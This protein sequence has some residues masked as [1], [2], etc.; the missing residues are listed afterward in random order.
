MSSANQA[1]VGRPA[2]A[3]R[4][5]INALRAL[6]VVLVVLYHFRVPPFSIGGFVGVDVFFVI[7]GYLMTRIVVSG[8]E[9][10]DFS[11]LKFYA[12]RARR[13]VPAL[14]ALSLAVLAVGWLVAL[15]RD[16]RLLGKHVVSAATF[17]SNI[18]F[19]REDG[20]FEADSA[21]KWLLHTWSVSVEWQF[22]LIYPLVLMAMWRG[23]AQS[24]RALC[25]YLAMLAVAGFVYCVVQGQLRP[26]WAFFALDSR[27][28]ELVIG[29]LLVFV[30]QL[31]RRT[32]RALAG[33]GLGLI[34]VSGLMLADASRWPGAFTLM[35][36]LGAAFV[37]ASRSDHA[38]LTWRPLQW[39]GDVSYSIY[40]W[41][42]PVV[43]TLSY[44]GLLA[45]PAMVT[46]GI[47]ASLILAQ[48]SYQFVEQ[49]ARQRISGTGRSL[50]AA[51]AAAVVV[52]V[53]GAVVYLGKGFPQRLS[54]E[55]RVAAEA[56][57]DFNPRRDECFLSG[58]AGED[59]GF[60]CQF[61]APAE[62][63]R[64][65]IVAGDSHSMSV[66]GAA[67]RVARELGVAVEYW[68]YS[69]CPFVDGYMRSELRCVERNRALEERINLTG[70]PVLLI[71]RWSA[72]F[73]GE[74]MHGADPVWLRK[75]AVG[76]VR[77]GEPQF[78]AAFLAG[79]QSAI[80]RITQVTSVAVLEPI[81]EMP[82]SVPKVLLRRALWPHN[83]EAVVGVSVADYQDR[84]RPVRDV[85][86]SLGAGCGA[87]LLDPLK[88]LCVDGICPGIRNQVAQYF[89]DD[90]LSEAGARHLEPLLRQWLS[91][92]M[93]AADM[94][95]SPE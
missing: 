72:Y 6:S 78:S 74:S 14:L 92:Q 53:L 8:L 69:S 64:T 33:L 27:A 68:G 91:S 76:G 16:Y 84:H 2:G 23:L 60:F 48:L 40:L 63:M 11:A 28:W 10:G 38:L 86:A 55:Q 41:H 20:Y 62:A 5:D 75:A 25:S 59:P 71:G 30:P 29:G 90:H 50:G 87:T 70:Y 89:D 61:G 80:C 15:D 18:A 44:L 83:G 32:T 39:T 67:D 3:F 95:R 54:A 82:T 22:Y 42:W 49:P 17:M 88:G 94:T 66:I 35:P 51:L 37:M 85:L 7:S 31:P 12:A 24:R 21:S 43:V 45:Q 36:V 58:K 57:R 79:I 56:M 46:A 65:V 73:L 9:R 19:A 52:S 4:A 81:P 77:S 93:E 1:Q 34:L 47:A 26:T 13:I